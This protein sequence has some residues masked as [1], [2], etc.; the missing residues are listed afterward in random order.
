MKNPLVFF[1]GAAVAAIGVVAAATFDRWQDWPAP[2]RTTGTPEVGDEYSAMTPEPEAQAPAPKAEAV[3]ETPSDATRLGD[4]AEVALEEP[5]PEP[6]E[7]VEAAPDVTGPVEETVEELAGDGAEPERLAAVDPQEPEAAAPDDPTVPEPEPEAMVSPSFDVVRLE[8]DGSLI[9]VGRA[10]PDGRQ[11]PERL[12][13][14]QGAARQPD[15]LAEVGM[16]A[17]EMA[18]DPK[19]ADSDFLPADKQHLIL[20]ATPMIG[21]SAGPRMVA[22]MRIRPTATRSAGGKVR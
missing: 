19:F 20:H 22:N 8:D 6:E 14:Q 21:P 10:A 12:V 17:N 2:L 11:Q 5:P 18:K 9:A 16:A 15:A 7:Q 1:V 4:E 3:E 13:M